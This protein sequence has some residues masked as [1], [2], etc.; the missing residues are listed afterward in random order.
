MS[1]SE[2]VGKILLLVHMSPNEGEGLG[3]MLLMVCI[4]PDSIGDHVASCTYCVFHA[5]MKR[6]RTW[7]MA[8]LKIAKLQGSLAIL[9][10]KIL[11]NHEA[12]KPAFNVGSSS[13]SQQ[14]AI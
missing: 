1:P 2:M 7:G 14:N 9:I 11:E 5:P 8:P 6:V 12:T 10:R 3:Y 13:A 4:S